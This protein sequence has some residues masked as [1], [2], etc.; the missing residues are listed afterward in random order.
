MKLKGAVIE[1]GDTLGDWM[2]LGKNGSKVPLSI[3][4]RVTE[5]DPSNVQKTLNDN[6]DKVEKSTFLQDL[7]TGG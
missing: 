3:E 5:S 7:V 6:A 4:I 2:L 1:Q